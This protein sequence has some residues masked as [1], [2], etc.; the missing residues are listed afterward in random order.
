MKRLA[1]CLVAVL[2]AA[3][4]V[5]AGLDAAHAQGIL[6]T[7]HNLSPS[8]PGPVKATTQTDTG[9][10]ANTEV[11]VYCHTPHGA[12]TTVAAPLWNRAVN[13][14]ANAY[15]MYSSPTLDGTIDAQPT[16]VSLACLSCHD[17]TI[18]FDALRNL[19]GSGGF[20]GSPATDGTRTSWTFAGTPD[21]K[22][23]A[24]GITNLGT[25]LSNDHPI[26]IDYASAKSPS[27][28]DGTNSNVGFYQPTGDTFGNGVRL[29]SGK[30]QCASCHDPHRSN[31]NTFLR[32]ANDGSALCL[33]CHKKNG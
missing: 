12:D 2:A 19:P 27:A 28:T 4:A 26:S 8:G 11:C 33:T 30:V 23:P 3:T 13:T 6:G 9:G 14:T 16:G 31:T 29:Y 24:G 1:R 18:A 25:D 5:G 15:T 10:Q 20:S 32:V 17:G 7:K 21:K 22:M